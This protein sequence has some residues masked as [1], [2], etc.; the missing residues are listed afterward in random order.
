MQ[1]SRRQMRA[2]PAPPRGGRAAGFTLIEIMAVVAIIAM[3]LGIGLPRLRASK[4]RA[5]ENEAESIA[6]SLEY[7]RQRAILTR[8]PHRVLIDLEEGGWRV[9]WLVNEERAFA[10]ITEDGGAPELP[11]PD[12]G[13]L[14]SADAREPIDFHPPARDELDYY[15]IP[16]R[17]LGGFT[18]LDES[19]YFVGLESA[20]GWIEG[21][22]VGIV[23]DADGTTDQ[24]RLELADS[25]DNHLTLEIEPLLDRVR[26]YEGR[27]RS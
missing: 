8:V 20:T 11:P 7:A 27:A 6:T 22:D 4:V 13:V 5:L 2:R 25:D 16:N 17:Q 9:E 21:G 14:P 18:W 23:F 19:R 12:P 15:P 10:A 1:T 3:I 24:A 26:R